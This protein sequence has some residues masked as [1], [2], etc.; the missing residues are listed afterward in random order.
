MSDRNFDTIAEHF[1]AKVYGGLKGQ[2]R[3]AVLQ[4]DLDKI[5]PKTP[6]KVLDV[7]AGLGQMSLYLA[8]LGHNCV[9]SDVSEVMLDKAKENY[10]VMLES[11][12]I[13]K[14]VSVRFL[15]APY[16][17]LKSCLSEYQDSFDVILCHAVLEWV[18]N[19]QELITVLTSLLKTDGLL[20]LCFYN[21]VAPIYRN[22]V[23]GNFNHLKNPKPAD[24]GSLTPN[25]PVSYEQVLGWLDGYRIAHESGIRVFYDYA[26]QKQG[27]LA[28]AEA[29]VEMELFYSDKLPFR[30]MGRYLHI[31]A[32]KGER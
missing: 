26:I 2:I 13:D 23:L 3:L 22:L 4:R 14:A 24:S 27:G 28:N 32:N 7:G 25:T 30:L 29:V 19:P 18:D 20:S 10:Q 15:H 5:L 9:L 11:G 31:L 12:A 6:L 17:M 8:S 21:P 16:Q 1:A